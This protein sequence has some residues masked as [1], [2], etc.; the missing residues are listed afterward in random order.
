MKRQHQAIQ[1]FNKGLRYACIPK[2]DLRVG[3]AYNRA[4]L[5]YTF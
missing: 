2:P 3:Y 5:L 4:I 1:V